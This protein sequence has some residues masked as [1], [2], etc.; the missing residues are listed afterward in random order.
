VWLCK[1]PG[2]SDEKKAHG[3]DGEQKHEI[4]GAVSVEGISSRTGEAWEHLFWQRN[5]VD[6]DI[7]RELA[8]THGSN[9]SLF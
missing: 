2:K 6:E 1:E 8:V 7:D 9:L 3:G 4:R 5:V